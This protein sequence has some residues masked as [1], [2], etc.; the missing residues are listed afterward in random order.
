MRTVNPVRQSNLER[1]AKPAMIPF[2]LVP[3]IGVPKLATEAG[4]ATGRVLVDTGLS[5]LRRLNSE[6]YSVWTCRK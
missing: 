6:P 5:G 2:R 3:V 1:E 4:Q